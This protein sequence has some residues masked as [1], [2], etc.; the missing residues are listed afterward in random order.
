[1]TRRTNDQNRKRTK[2]SPKRKATGSPSNRPS[3]QPRSR[4]DADDRDHRAFTAR[5]RTRSDEDHR[6][7]GER[8][9]E[10]RGLV[11]R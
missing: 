5:L 4:E 1:M 6:D 9:D 3:S 7:P 8:W 2:T 11:E 10:Q